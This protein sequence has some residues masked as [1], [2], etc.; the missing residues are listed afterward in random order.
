MFGLSSAVENIEQMKNL[1]PVSKKLTGWVSKATDPDVIK[2]A[3]S[4]T[5]VGHQLHPLATDLPM[6]AWS[7]A[8]LLDITG[9]GQ[10]HRAAQH[11]VGVGILTS[12]PA[13]AS[14]ASD[15]SETIGESRRVGLVHALGNAAGTC[16]QLGSWIARRSG[17]NR[18][19]A[20]L[21]LA[22]LTSTMGAAYLGGHLSL[23]MG[24]GVNQTAGEQKATQ[25]VEVATEDDVAEGQLTRVTANDTP[26]VLTR[27]RGQLRA[28]SA[29][30]PHAGGSLDEGHIENDCVVCPL[31][32][33]K[34]RLTD[35]Q[36]ERGPTAYPAPSW[37]V[38][39]ADG[40]IAIKSV[41]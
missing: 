28:L 15:W 5:W 10:M 3:L 24:V 1:D 9:R 37:R 33:S 21:S 17:H 2:N 30:C 14:G 8:S 4:G 36:P 38:R 31:H 6:G 7:M 41:A 11:L 19:G 29:T 25:W 20:T 39:E 26:V 35:G 32:Q 18:L 13:A 12:L 27:H 34:F 22:G 23:D 40:R 16:L